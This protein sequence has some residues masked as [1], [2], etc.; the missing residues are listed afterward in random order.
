MNMIARTNKNMMSEFKKVIGKL[1]STQISKTIA[2]L[3]ILCVLL[4]IFQPDTF[5]TFNNL[6]NV[7]RQAS[8]NTIMVVG[9]SFVLITGGIDLSVGSVAG[10]TGLITAMLIKADVNLF[11]AIPIALT[12][13]LAIGFASGLFITKLNIP[14]FISTLAMLTTFR[15][16]INVL[17]QGQPVTRL[18]DTFD[19]IGTGYIGPVPFPM[20]LMLLLVLV[21]SYVLKSTRF[22]RH[23]YAVGGNTEAA[24]LSGIKTHKTI[25]TCYMLSALFASIAGLVMTARVDSATP[26]AGSGAELDAIAAA[27]IG[28]ISL[29]GGKGNVAGGLIGAL[30]IAVLNNGMVLMNVSVFY[31]LVVKGIIILLAVIIDSVSRIKDE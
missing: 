8:I 26:L 13:G 14:P 24:R 23:V 1:F 29:S 4:S 22:G 17:S 12:L 25:I 7:F 3:I 10:L 5:F 21:I 2:A 30:I 16:V 18:G 31:T 9:L 15:G 19:F 11:L 28:G 6:F 20:I 27:V